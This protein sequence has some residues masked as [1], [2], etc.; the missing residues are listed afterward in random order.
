MA[1]GIFKTFD[2]TTSGLRA[3]WKRMQVVANNVANADTTRTPEG[4]PYQRKHVVF[5]T[6][7]N[8]LAGVKVE[9][10]VADGEPPKRV[11]SPGHPE[12]DAEGYLAMPNVMVPVEM[13]DLTTASRAYEANL[14]AM[15][16]FRKICEETIKLLKS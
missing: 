3:Q 12:A 14:L 4:G 10:V 1:D 5:S 7:L 9:G 15:R 2:I 13:V 8:Q 11:Y 16:N 6:V